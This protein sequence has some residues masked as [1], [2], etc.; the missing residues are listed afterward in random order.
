MNSQRPA[1][2]SNLWIYHLC[3]L[4]TVTAWGLSLVSTRILLDHG[5]HPVEIFIYRSI[6]AYLA[7]LCFCHKKILANSVKDELLFVA[8][9]LV[10]GSVYFIAENVALE[11]TLVTNVS[12]ITA[13]PPLLTVLLVGLVYKNNRPG[14]GAYIGSVVAFLGV[15]LVIFNSSFNMALNPLGDLL[16]LLAAFCWA[17]YGLMLKPLNAHYTEMFITRKVFFYG[18]LTALPFLAVEPEVSDPRILLDPACLWN[19]LFLALFC[20]M[21]GY[22]LWAVAV[23]KIGPVTAT[24]YMYFQPVITMIFAMLALNEKITPTGYAGCALILLGVWLADFL[25]RRSIKKS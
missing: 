17:I 21:A 12:L 20:S 8:C 7:I 5:L 14:R 18:V 1:A 9:G 24:N 25:Q 22:L 10:A 6:L 4:F 2:K 19:L 3:A 23:V 11:Y 15:G 13:M 16:S